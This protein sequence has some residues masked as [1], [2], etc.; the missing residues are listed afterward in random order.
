MRFP[1]VQDAISDPSNNTSTNPHDDLLGLHFNL[2]LPVQMSP[3]NDTQVQKLREFDIEYLE[4][5]D[6]EEIL[7]ESNA[8][9]GLTAQI[10]L[11]PSSPKLKRLV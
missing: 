3:D 6:R 4:T 8:G 1:G 5:A 7:E 9:P 2:A 10:N 11:D